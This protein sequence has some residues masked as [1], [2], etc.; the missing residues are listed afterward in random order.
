LKASVVD[1]RY[2]MADVLSALDKNESVEILYHGRVKGI[3]EPVSEKSCKKV[4][5][6]R[7][8]R[9]ASRTKERVEDSM[10]KLRGRRYR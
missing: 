7:F 1:L 4:R 2:E 5:E 3:I 8:F 6:H 9:L 10:E